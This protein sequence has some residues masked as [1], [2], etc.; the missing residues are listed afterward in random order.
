MSLV[1]VLI[2]MVLS[3][4][5]HGAAIFQESRS[6]L[7]SLSKN[8]IIVT[9][10][11]RHSRAGTNGVSTGAGILGPSQNFAHYNG[12]RSS[13]FS[14]DRLPFMGAAAA[15]IC[16]PRPLPS[17][18][19]QGRPV[20]GHRGSLRSLQAG[21]RASFSKL[22]T[23]PDPLE[24]QAGTTTDSAWGP[25]GCTWAEG[26]WE[27]AWPLQVKTTPGKRTGQVGMVVPTILKNLIGESWQWALGG[28]GGEVQGCS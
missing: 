15:T 20:R 5:Q 9:D 26:P 21:A 23:A 17:T 2:C 7:Q 3:P 4:P 19:H 25:G 28:A 11:S 16:T 12:T 24:G 13:L 8:L 18:S 22:P 10:H 6:S 14:W 27:A 1:L